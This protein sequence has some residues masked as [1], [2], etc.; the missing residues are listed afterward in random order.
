MLCTPCIY[1]YNSKVHIPHN[2]EHLNSKYGFLQCLCFLITK[3]QLSLC[4]SVLCMRISWSRWALSWLHVARHTFDIVSVGNRRI[5]FLFNWTRRWW[6][7]FFT[8]RSTEFW[9]VL[10][11]S[12]ASRLLAFYFPLRRK[13]TGP[14]S[15]WGLLPFLFRH[16][17]IFIYLFIYL[18]FT[19]MYLHLF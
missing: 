17:S 6:W 10:R 18:L 8:R 12:K 9:R 4:L 19:Y 15:N 3:K 2:L 14:V 7:L 5:G 1:I 16:T 13:L 11:G